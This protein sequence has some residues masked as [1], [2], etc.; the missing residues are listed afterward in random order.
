MRCHL[1]R[2][3]GTD[4]LEESAVCILRLGPF[5][6][7]AQFKSTLIRYSNTHALYS[8]KVF[9]TLTC[10]IIKLSAVCNEF[11]YNIWMLCMK[12]ICYFLLY[13]VYFCILT[14]LQDLFHILF[15]P[16]LNLG[17]MEYIKYICCTYVCQYGCSRYLLGNITSQY[18]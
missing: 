7:K 2:Y 16:W 15:V 1:I 18:S 12:Y 17:S 3:I 5:C 11:L 8:F 10:F 6:W 4:V 13:I 9:L 14:H